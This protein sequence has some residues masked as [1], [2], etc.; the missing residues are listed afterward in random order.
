MARSTSERKLKI[1]TKDDEKKQGLPLRSIVRIIFSRLWIIG[2]AVAVFTGLAVG[3]SLAQT[4]TYEASVM[5]LVGQRQEEGAVSSLGD[6]IV[7]S[8]ELTKT[9]AQAADSRPVAEV[10]IKRLNLETTPD[11]L[12][13]NLEAQQVPKTL[14]VQL[15]YEDPNPQK[16]QLVANTAGQV[17]SERVSEVSLETYAI[18]ATVWEPAATPSDPVSPNL[19]LNVFISLVVGVALGLT[20]AFLSGYLGGGVD[21]KERDTDTKKERTLLHAAQSLVCTLGALVVVTVY[22]IVPLMITLSRFIE[23][24]WSRLSAAVV[25]LVLGEVA[26]FLILK[27]TSKEYEEYCAK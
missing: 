3:F 16:A 9:I 6:N 17:L 4:P 5:I 14:F 7:G 27:K 13:A 26:V 19:K 8:Q 12:L 21:R 2:L 22:L 15:N 11:N 20:L 10:V 24:N 1:D 18:T 25:L 23:S